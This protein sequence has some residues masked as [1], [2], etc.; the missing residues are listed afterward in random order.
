MA[1]KQKP[2]DPLATKAGTASAVLQC[3]AGHAREQADHFLARCSEEEVDAFASC[4]NGNAFSLLM[5][6]V[7]DRLEATKPE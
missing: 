4:E 2:D 7:L 6:K 1:T 5:D 3:M